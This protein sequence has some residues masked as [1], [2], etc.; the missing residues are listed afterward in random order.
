MATSKHDRLMELFSVARREERPLYVQAPMVRYSKLPFRLLVAG[1]GTDVVYTPMIV[2]DAFLKSSLSRDCELMTSPAETAPLI[3]QFAAANTRQF[4]DASSMVSQ[5]VSGV[6][7][8]CGCPQG[9]AMS[10]GLGSALIAKPELVKDMIATT[11]AQAEC[12]VTVKIRL[13]DTPEETIEL[14]RRLEAAGAAWIT[15][16]GRTP[17][18]KR[19]GDVDYDA[20]AL[21]ASAVGIPV[22][23]N[24]DIN[25]VADA[26]SVAAATGV[27]GVMSARG[28]LANPAMFAGLD[29]TP[30][31]AV[32]EYI[33]LSLAYSEKFV[34]V[35]YH[36]LTMTSAI[37][38][39]WA[40]SALAEVHTVSDIFDLF[41]SRFNIDL[42]PAAADPTNSPAP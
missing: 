5:Y 26:H 15:I 7:L 4:V 12:P 36:V 9:W 14:V 8:N 28:L 42:S 38:P 13:R 27:D 32:R 22:L 40:R 17:A 41:L 29:Y 37:L 11:V 16:H 6:D 2:S 23:A 3:V 39:R 24:G 21:A 18:N 33:R 34:R 19:G 30:I 10:D 35:R 1:Y 25:S 20:I 31:E